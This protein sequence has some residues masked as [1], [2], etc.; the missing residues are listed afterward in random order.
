MAER[1]IAVDHSAACI[2]LATGRVP[3]SESARV[4]LHAADLRELPLADD[5]VDAIASVG[6]IQHIPTPEARLDALRELRRVL[7]PGGR[8]LAIVYRWRGHIRREREGYFPNGIYRY[9]F[10]ALE[11]R[12]AFEQA[13]FAD[14][15]TNGIVVAPGIAQRLGIG[16][17]TQRRLG[18]NL[19]ARPF[20]H[21]L[22]ATAVSP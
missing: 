9:A 22:L 10:T 21:H 20:A 17:E 14:I 18:R 3:E 7:R 19:L 12:G 2:E 8:I 6:V 1:V 16:V 11:L 5:A 4:S 13:G 15:E